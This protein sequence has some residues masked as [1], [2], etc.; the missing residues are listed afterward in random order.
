MHSQDV[1]SVLHVVAVA[2]QAAH[3]AVGGVLGQLVRFVIEHVIPPMMLKHDVHETR[4]QT[5]QLLRLQAWAGLIWVKRLADEAINFQRRHTM[6]FK[7]EAHFRPGIL[8]IELREAQ[9]ML[10]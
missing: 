1:Q 8:C 3:D 4:E 2:E 7:R 10:I 6:R 9:T 5:I